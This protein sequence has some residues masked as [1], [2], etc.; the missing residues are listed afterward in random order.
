MTREELFS[1]ICVKKSFLCIGLD[2]DI[3]RIPKH[4][5]KQ[6]DPVFEFN[7]QIIEATKEFCVAFKPNLAFYESQGPAGLTS[8][9]K[10]MRC[11][12]E[13]VF[14]IAD[15]KRGDIGNTS[16]MYARTFY[17]YYHFDSV[18][19]APY[20]G[21]DSVSPFL[22]QGKWVILLAL[23]SNAGSMDFQLNEMCSPVSG[24]EEKLYEHVLRTSQKWADA[25]QMM[26]VIGATHPELLNTVRSIVP[27]HFLLVPG[28]GAQGGS[29]EEVAHAGLNKQCGLLVNSSRQIIYASAGEDFAEAAR[30][31]AKRTAEEMAMLLERHEIV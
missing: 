3:T 15:A 1:Q 16:E 28:V 22:R 20:M 29:L 25:G 8:L 7:R 13:S 5:L 19:V 21:K 31:E 23:T 12:P 26:Y 17:D 10:T 2:T 14:T 6:D 24:K 18:T 4:L 30:K 9:E 11:I 27:D